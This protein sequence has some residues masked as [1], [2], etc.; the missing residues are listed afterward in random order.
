MQTIRD[1]IKEKHD[2]ANQAATLEIVDQIVEWTGVSLSTMRG[3]HRTADIIV[4]RRALCFHL[5]ERLGLT[6]KQIGRLL[7]VD[8]STA[9]HHIKRAKELMALYKHGFEYELLMRAEDFPKKQPKPMT[10]TTGRSISPYVYAICKHPTYTR[11]N[12]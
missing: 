10:E 6:F 5:R 8:H 7:G 9:V 12:S 4:A 11:K 3:N 2:A 1:Y